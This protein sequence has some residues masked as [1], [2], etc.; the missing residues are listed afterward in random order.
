MCLKTGVS[1]YFIEHE[2]IKQNQAMSVAENHKNITNNKHV[3]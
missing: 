1:L 3:K 2:T